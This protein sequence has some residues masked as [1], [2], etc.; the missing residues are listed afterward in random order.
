MAG[1]T[2]LGGGTLDGANQHRRPIRIAVAL[3]LVLLPLQFAVTLW[4]EEVYP[5]ITGPGFA[6]RPARDG[7]VRFVD[8]A[9]RVACG[10][11]EVRQVAC[12][13]LIAGAGHRSVFVL[14][15]AFPASAPECRANGP[16]A[17]LRGP[18]AGCG[19]PSAALRSWML[20]HA[21][22]AAHC[23]DPERLEIV[24]EDVAIDLASR[25]MTRH[26]RTRHGLVFSA[27]EQP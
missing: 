4:V 11:G 19:P 16:L 12:E 22:R 20:V 1:R 26:L 13:D 8:C 6:G 10:D 25:T 5:G 15:T 24:W 14:R 18:P 2:E 21:R 17:R 7:V 27:A 3:L 23:P 9:A